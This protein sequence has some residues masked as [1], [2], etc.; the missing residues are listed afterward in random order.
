MTNASQMSRGVVYVFCGAVLGMLG[1]KLHR[2]FF[3]KYAYS[4]VLV[5]S[6]MLFIQL[7]SLNVDDVSYIETYLQVFKRFVCK[8]ICKTVVISLFS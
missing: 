4:S 8:L 1:N 3:Q 7:M 2:L 6:V 5:I